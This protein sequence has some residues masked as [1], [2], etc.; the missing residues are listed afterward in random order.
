MNEK[1][2]RVLEYHKIIEKLAGFAQ[3]DS[4]RE[5]V[6][7]LKPVSDRMTIEQWQEETSE[8]ESILAVE[9]SGFLSSFP[10]IRQHIR[11]AI[12][13]SVLSPKELLQIAQVLSLISSVKIRMNE[14]KAK[15]ELKWIP[16]MVAAMQTQRVLLDSIRRCIETED[17]LY[18]H[19]SPELANIRRQIN[20]A[21]ERVRERLNSYL[22][23]PQMLKFLQEPIITMR[24][25]RYVLP[26]KQE[27]RSQMPGIVHDQSSSGATLFI[28]PMSVV[29]AN[30]EIRQLMIKEADEVERIL[31]DLTAQVGAAGEEI[32]SAFEILIRLDFIFAKGAFSIS[33]R[34][35]RPSIADTPS[36]YIKNGRHP[37]I[38][39]NV[40]VP[41]T[42]EL[43]RRF[44]TLVITGPNT[45]GKTVTLKTTGL[46]VLM[47]QAGLHL[48][49]DYGTALGVFNNVYADIG[50]E[51]SI[52]QSLSTFSSHMSNI[53][54]I[55]RNVN[56]YD[57]V[58]FDELGAGTDPTEGAAL[59]MSI[60]DHL[61]NRNIRT[62]ATTHYSEL[63]VYAIK[64][65]GVENAS[66][67]FDVE[68]LRPT[69][70]LLI[71]VPGKSNAF[72]ISRRL[73]LDESLIDGARE[74]LS[75]ENVRFEDIMGDIERNRIAAEQERQQSK[76]YLAEIEAIKEKHE[77]ELME[78]EQQ[79]A[80]LLNKAREEARKLI[81]NAR[82]E[83]D[84]IIKELQKLARE[85]EEKERNRAIEEARKKLKN[86]FERL[87][88]DAR[89]KTALS[90]RMP[91]RNLQL[92]QTVYLAS[93][94]QKGQVLSMPD[95]E[96]N[97]LVQVGIM[98]VNANISDLRQA[99]EDTAVSVKSGRKI[100]PRTTS[101]SSELDLRGMNS[102]EAMAET[103]I[104]LDNAFL[105]GLNE[106]TII[107]GKGTG[108][109]RNSIHQLLKKHP[110]VKSYRLG[111]FGEG[112]TGVTV[113]EIK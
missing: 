45:G 107:H 11:K 110:H 72:E 113:V 75:Q 10:N 1:T 46:F 14:H 20:R 34:G 106:V 85:T 39:P 27:Y 26:V 68:T 96:G 48:P 9:G 92:G 60:L 91:L 43:G 17:T 23:S 37:L 76:A 54:Q 108:I 50:D 97:L 61:H 52:E 64:R 40:V 65:E 41:I 95:E 13:G 103:D 49:A 102:E 93:L 71:G 84:E 47:A 18:D 8:A 42:L 36:L 44:T 104:Y 15:A 56:P 67:E 29:E 105:A 87:E 57:L 16:S 99:E 109:L 32:L 79:K 86:T 6:L 3:S 31:A 59:A 111:K 21:N 100:T 35:V 77:K 90:P 69:Y 5:L 53:V 28:E 88:G 112:E 55:L 24:N 94:D 63:K 98:K 80:K 38:D 62:M 22:H 19:A 30:N 4:G 81:Q 12:I 33:I 25:G 58:L 78:F 82:A 2:L 74:Y 51:Q 7:Q 70:R 89:H 73:G 83:A 66:V 101:V